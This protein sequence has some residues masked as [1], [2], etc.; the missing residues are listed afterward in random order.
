[1]AT[2][3]V[4]V[5]APMVTAPSDGIVSTVLPQGFLL[6]IVGEGEGAMMHRIREFQNMEEATECANFFADHWHDPR[7][8]FQVWSNGQCLYI[9]RN[10]TKT[11]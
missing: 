11:E 5:H 9:V 10:A 3:Y 4:D 6:F 2:A 8:S 1:M 7:A